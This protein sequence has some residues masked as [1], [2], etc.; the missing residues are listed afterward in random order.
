MKLAWCWRCRNRVTDPTGAVTDTYAYDAF[1][2]TVAQTGTTFN[3]FLYRGEQFDSTL[4]IYY[5]RTRY[6]RPQVGRFLTADKYEGGDVGACN[7][8]H[9]DSGLGPKGPHHLF[10]YAGVDPVNVIDPTG[11]ANFFFNTLFGYRWYVAIGGILLI[12]KYEICAIW[13]EYVLEAEK[14]EG[15]GPRMGPPPPWLFCASPHDEW[16]RP[17]E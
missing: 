11:R 8:S 10:D 12:I 16:P 13:E 6:Y 3:Q 5:L 1:G 15:S 14:A 4:G 17:G 7:C 9:W 2:N